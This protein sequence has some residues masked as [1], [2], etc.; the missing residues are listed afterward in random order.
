MID[1]RLVDA[2]TLHYWVLKDSLQLFVLRVRRCRDILGREYRSALMSE[3]VILLE[4]DICADL[5]GQFYEGGHLAEI[6]ALH[7]KC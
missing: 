4:D 3:A 1:E 6:G 2:R 7:Y 5:L